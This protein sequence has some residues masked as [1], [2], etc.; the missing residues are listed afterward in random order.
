[1]IKHPATLEEVVKS[2]VEHFQRRQARELDYFARVVRS[3][4]DAVSQA[5]LAR[6]PSGKRHQHQRRIPRAA[7]QESRARLLSNLGALRRSRTFDD[8]L[9]LVSALI[10]PIPGIGELAVYDTALRIGARFDVQP[11]VV[12]L[13]AGTRQGARA[14]GFDPRRNKIRI[15]EL[16]AALQTLSAREVEDLLCIYKD[17][18]SITAPRRLAP[19]ERIGKSGRAVSRSAH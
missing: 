15:D 10:R 1:V 19:P 13:H 7:L 9:D 17:K 12:Y 5:G 11:K 6:L 3:D 14:L 4:E 18:L 2:Y 16:P 8:L